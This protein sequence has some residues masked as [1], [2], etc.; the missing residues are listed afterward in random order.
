MDSTEIYFVFDPGNHSTA[1]YYSADVDGKSVKDIA[2]PVVGL[3]VQRAC[4]LHLPSKYYAEPKSK[5]AHI[6]NHVAF[7]KVSLH[8][9]GAQIKT[10]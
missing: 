1:S 7:Y 5:A 9:L 10:G 8:L 2:W 3:D 6:K 4:F